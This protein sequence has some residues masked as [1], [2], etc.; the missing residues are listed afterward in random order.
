MIEK[1]K[2]LRDNWKQIIFHYDIDDILMKTIFR[3]DN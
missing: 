1:S 3:N 2:N